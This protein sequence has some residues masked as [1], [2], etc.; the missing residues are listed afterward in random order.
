[1][2]SI[3]IPES[4]PLFLLLALLAL[5]QPPSDASA[6]VINFDDAPDGTMINTRYPGIT[7]TNPVGGNIFA[8][9]S[10]SFAPSSPNVAS[11]FGTGQG[12]PPYEARNGAVDAI[13]ATP[14][15]AV[16]IDARPVAPLEFLTP[17]TRRPYFEVYNTSG[18]LIG[19][20]YYVGALPTTSGGVGPT[21]TLSFTSTA[22]DIGRVRFSVQSSG[23]TI[24]PTYGLFDNL[25]FNRI[26]SL[27]AS[28][29]SGGSVRYSPEQNQFIEGALVTLNAV[30]QAGWRFS[31]WSGD[32]SGSVN[33]L[34]VTMTANKSIIANFV[35]ALPVPEAIH[36]ADFDSGVPAGVTLFGDARVH[37]GSLKLHTVGQPNSFGIAYIDDFN[38][39]APVGGFFARFKVALF[40]STC[41][42]GGF[43]PADGFSFNL[44]PA[45]TVLPN[46]G[47]GEP[48]EEGLTNG[49][50]VN[51][52]TWDN[53]GGEAPAIDVKWLGQTIVS[54]PIQ[55]SQSPSGITDPVAAQREVI[56]WL[57]PEGII[58]VSYGGTYVLVN[59]QTPY[60]A[61]KIGVPK[62]VLGARV[63]DANDN[64]WISDLC[65][66]TI[67]GGQLCEGF[68]G[69][70]FGSASFY[71]DAR[72][73]GD[74]LKLHSVGET[75]SF[76]I[77]HFDDFSGGQF[78]RAFRAEFKASL[79]GS[80]CCGGGAFP[81]DGF[82]FNLVPAATILSNPGYGQP[83]E[84][85]LD[86]GLAVNFDTWDNGFGEAPAIE[87]KWKGQIIT[88]APFQASQSV[89]GATDPDLAEQNVLI[90]LKADG[91]VTVGYGGLFAPNI[92]LN[93]VPTPYDPA[94]IGTP[95]WVMGAR[96]GGANDNHWFDEL[97][98]TTVTAP[99]R[100]I[101]GLYNTGVDDAG[102]PLQDNDVD[103]HYRLTFGGST[104][105]VATESEGF[106]IPPW[107]GS[108]SMSAWISPAPDTYGLSD[109]LGSYTYRYTT[110][111]DLTGFD[112][113]TA[114]IAGRWAT[115]N[116]G[117]QILVNG[118]ESFLSNTNQFTSW[119]PFTLTGP[120]FPGTNTLTFLV[121]N[122]SPG[123]PSGSDPTGLRVELWGSAQVD[124]GATGVSPRINIARGTRAVLLFWSAGGHVL[125]GAGQ[126]SG[127]W[128]DLT[129]GAS[130]NGRDHFATL[131]SAGAYR[132]FRLRRDCEQ[133]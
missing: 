22:N 3:R 115:D 10:A 55:V 31:H 96:V 62:W 1:M 108:N 80:T 117:V 116:V 86:E 112:P 78:V 92:V 71:G 28:A 43:F 39:G 76:G 122:G 66:Q 19:Q 128:L 27:A 15:G 42:G 4:K 46:P 106:P 44:V 5:A 119:T 105:Y 97:C 33:P 91:R 59:V 30:S 16:S 26:F 11:I 68:N 79:F 7:F 104:A 110:T 120:F 111:F 90:E 49:L 98:I 23:G 13:L 123:A 8:R 103:P 72:V 84:E 38:G 121:N 34:Q 81:A 14:V 130:A 77:V 73:H 2:I 101:P 35:P 127:P 126:V 48:G 21:E 60:R 18:A 129:R 63:G 45:A 12:L 133:P 40:G 132:F 58:S 61:S 94:A 36:C 9:N 24:T 87:I 107:L 50:S 88:N 25:N 51:F 124:C 37:E 125:Q 53:G 32:A 99:A 57:R 54:A 52:D 118:F 20:I 113:F 74:R 67:A 75:N 114:R 82:S 56:I 70:V 29:S 41:C 95:K 85:G 83:G 131:P 69:G 47:Y 17:L 65:I 102:R 89:F 93:N 64:H 100:P 109:G 6:A